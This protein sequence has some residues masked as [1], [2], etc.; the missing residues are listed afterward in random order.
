M[1]LSLDTSI[2]FTDTRHSF[3]RV[4][5]IGNCRAITTRMMLNRDM[6]VNTVCAFKTSPVRT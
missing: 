2:L 3:N 5:A 4:I 1:K 6:Q